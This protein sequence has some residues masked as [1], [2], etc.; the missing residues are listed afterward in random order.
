M[1]SKS[2][3]QNRK[4]WQFDNTT[5][6]TF[7]QAIERSLRVLKDKSVSVWK[8]AKYSVFFDLSETTSI[9]ASHRL[10]IPNAEWM[11]PIQPSELELIRI[12]NKVKNYNVLSKQELNVISHQV[13]EYKEK[14]FLGK[15]WWRLFNDDPIDTYIQLDE[16]AALQQVR[17]IA[18]TDG[19]AGIEAY[20]R[21]GLP[22]EVGFWDRL[23]MGWRANLEDACSDAENKAL[24]QAISEIEQF[25]ANFKCTC[26]SLLMTVFDNREKLRDPENDGSFF[27]PSLQHLVEKKEILEESMARIS[28]Q[29]Q[30]FLGQKHINQIES[31]IS[32]ISQDMETEQAFFQTFC[33]HKNLSNDA[34]EWRLDELEK[35]TFLE[36]QQHFN[37]VEAGMEIILR[38]NKTAQQKLN[39]L[40]KIDMSGGSLFYDYFNKMDANYL[41]KSMANQLLCML[42]LQEIRCHTIQQ[43]HEKYKNQLREQIAMQMAERRLVICEIPLIEISNDMLDKA[44]KNPLEIPRLIAELSKL[45][46]DSVDR[47]RKSNTRSLDEHSSIYFN[48]LKLV[49]RWLEYVLWVRGYTEFTKEKEQSEEQ[50]KKV[51]ND[52]FKIYHPDKNNRDD[53]M[54][55]SLNEQKKCF[56]EAV[57]ATVEQTIC[58]KW[59]SSF[60]TNLETQSYQV[61]MNEI[62]KFDEK[63]K[64]EIQECG[65]RLQKIEA[66]VEQLSKERIQDR[67]AR[68]AMLQ[69]HFEVQKKLD[70]EFKVELEQLREERIQEREERI[71]EHEALEARLQ[72]GREENNRKFEQLFALLQNKQGQ[73]LQKNEENVIP[74]STQTQTFFT[75]KQL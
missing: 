53:T 65:K 60:S 62:E 50:I 5:R 32:S 1:F 66:E 37:E 7:V 27:Q 54:S 19:V 26:S 51:H 20:K 44:T 56:E 75:N 41:N 67:E 59:L 47:H 42:R 9:S 22:E 21:S 16:I 4:Q 58:P 73:N 17:E 6:N 55:N 43:K 49:K 13:R 36:V 45:L 3:K 11:E 38:E 46:A 30:R 15:V 48:L 64:K 72:Q 52:L 39:N 31:L 70:E 8:D 23:T 33:D 14:S 68:E 10:S 57:A 28:R 12:S 2:N 61:A 34:E 71:Q 35:T 69:R 63:I 74:S 40:E 25:H 29:F 24:Q 18:L